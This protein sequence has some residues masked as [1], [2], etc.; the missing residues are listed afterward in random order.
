MNSQ[1]AQ[2][3]RIFTAKEIMAFQINIITCVI[4]GTGIFFVAPAGLGQIL[5]VVF[6]SA[7]MP[8]PPLVI[9]LSRR[10]AGK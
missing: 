5:G 8:V 1:T 7:L 2:E 3:S 10:R 4:I 9:Y 6:A